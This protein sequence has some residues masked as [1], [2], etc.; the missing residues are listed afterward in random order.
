[1]VS[2]RR[3]L[4]LAANLVACSNQ[5]G[6]STSTCPDV[7][8][9]AR[10]VDVCD[11][12]SPGVDTAAPTAG[13]PEAIFDCPTEPQDLGDILLDGSPS[14]AGWPGHGLLYHWTVLSSPAN[15]ALAFANPQASKPVLYG[16]WVGEF[17]V[18]LVVS[19]LQAGPGAPTVCRFETA[20]PRGLLVE[21]WWLETTDPWL[22]LSMDLDLHL[23]RGDVELYDERNDAWWQTS[24]ALDWGELAN[25][26]DDPRIRD[27]VKASI[28]EQAVLIGPEADQT[29]T[30]VALGVSADVGVEPAQTWARIWLDGTLLSEQTV[31]MGVNEVWTI[32]RLT[33]TTWQ[34]D[35]TVGREL[36]P[37]PGGA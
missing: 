30:V 14:D 9:R 22:G 7:A 1:M 37:P 16:S 13:V 27:V 17:T 20:A 11:P 6:R 33:G 29:Y 8:S 28:P 2:Q 36:H 25:A 19:D 15:R 23:L 21:L 32:G 12:T 35:N 24:G 3:A 18:S 5:D 4:F 26:T 31:T 34:V 10:L